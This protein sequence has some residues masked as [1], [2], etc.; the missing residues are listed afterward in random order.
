MKSI[1]Q[2]GEDIACKFLKKEK[3]KVIE[4]NFTCKQGEIDLIA[5]DRD[6]TLCFVEVKARSSNDYGLPEEAVTYRKQLKLLAAANVYIEKNQIKSQAMRFDIASI[7]LTDNTVRII[8]NAFE[9]N[10]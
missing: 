9:N 10:I 7:N 1:G 8:K 4:K 5:Q 3:Y 2:K 6:G